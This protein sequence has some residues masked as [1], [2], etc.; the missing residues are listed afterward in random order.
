M[1]LGAVALS[2]SV[3]APLPA[4]AQQRDRIITIFGDDRCPSSQGQEIVVCVRKPETERYRIPQIFRDDDTSPASTSWAAR[5][6]SVE[7]VGQTGSG[8]CSASGSSAWQGCL[9]KMIDEA[10][11][12]Q[13]A[14][15]KADAGVP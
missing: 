3:L 4:L 2:G 6:Q 12:A 13:Q 11:A 1:L 8:S 15:K 10:K 5:A 14:Q 7:Y 9:Q